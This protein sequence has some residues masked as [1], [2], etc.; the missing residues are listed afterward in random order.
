MTSLH[1]SALAGFLAVPAGKPYHHALAHVEA[2]SIDATDHTQPFLEPL[3]EFEASWRRLKAD[4]A[5]GV[6]V[7][8]S[9]MVPVSYGL[10]DVAQADNTAAGRVDLT[11]E[12]HSLCSIPVLGEFV[13]ELTGP[14]PDRRRLRELGAPFDAWSRF[15]SNGRQAAASL[16][17]RGPT[18]WHGSLGGDWSGEVCRQILLNT[19]YAKWRDRRSRRLCRLRVVVHDVAP[20]S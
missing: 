19:R 3:L 12:L 4:L 5:G 11:Q 1:P 14:A 17:V 18:V 20:S 8:P 7:N 10:V 2:S 13:H 15:E 9:D 6:P 16:T